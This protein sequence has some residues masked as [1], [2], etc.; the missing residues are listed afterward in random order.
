MLETS[1]IP[2]WET[3]VTKAKLAQI[4]KAPKPIGIYQWSYRLWDAH[5]PVERVVELQIH[6]GALSIIAILTIS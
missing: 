6:H 3:E 2:A 1:V 5:L 4:L